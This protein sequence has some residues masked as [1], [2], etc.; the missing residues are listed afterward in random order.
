MSKMDNGAWD[1]YGII[2]FGDLLHS[3]LVFELAINIAHIIL[4]SPDPLTAAG[5][6]IA[7][8]NSVR[9]LPQKEFDLLKVS[10]III[11]FMYRVLFGL[12]VSMSDY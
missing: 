3:C 10:T 2:D 8:Y 12:V 6:I 7:G 4:F 9:P 5:H 1:V 11:L